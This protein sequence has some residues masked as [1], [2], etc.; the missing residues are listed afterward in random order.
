M[1]YWELFKLWFPERG[2]SPARPQAVRDSFK[3][4]YDRDT[5]TVRVSVTWR[6]PKRNVNIAGSGPDGEVAMR[7]LVE[8]SEARW[9][10]AMA[11]WATEI[12]E[13]DG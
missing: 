8:R 5:R 9:N 13:A 10:D 7:E 4:R 1:D 2:V 6:F 3:V 12:L 11:N